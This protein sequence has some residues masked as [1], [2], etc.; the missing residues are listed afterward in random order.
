AVIKDKKTPA[1]IAKFALAYFKEKANAE[2]AEQVQRYF[3]EPV[4]VYGLS[5]NLCMTWQKN[6]IKKLSLTGV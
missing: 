4:K 3:K 2:K 1:Q 6:F 5:E